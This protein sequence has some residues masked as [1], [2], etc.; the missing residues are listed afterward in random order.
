MNSGITD[1]HAI[2]LGVQVWEK[3]A[4]A[5]KLLLSPGGEFHACLVGHPHCWKRATPAFLLRLETP[6]LMPESPAHSGQ[7]IAHIASKFIGHGILQW[8]AHTTANATQGQWLN[9]C[10]S[11]ASST[12]SLPQC[13]STFTH[14]VN[15]TRQP[16]NSRQEQGP[17][18]YKHWTARYIYA[19]T[20]KKCNIRR[21][22]GCRKITR[23]WLLCHLK[24]IRRR[25]GGKGKGLYWPIMSA[26]E[27][28]LVVRIQ[29]AVPAFHCP[30]HECARLQCRESGG[31]YCA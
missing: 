13:P 14:K 17:N 24:L 22:L 19:S 15:L 5:A 11:E 26:V 16:A 4:S 9:L 7:R 27:A 21:S 18:K 25:E 10:Q 12:P 2:C 20:C 3:Y 6:L 30:Q 31:K 29:S 8:P 1:Q 23:C 28:L